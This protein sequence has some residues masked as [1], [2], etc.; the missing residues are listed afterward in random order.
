MVFSGQK[1]SGRLRSETATRNRYAIR[2]YLDTA[3]KHGEPVITAIRDALTGTPGCRPS[4]HEH[5]S[6]FHRSHNAIGDNTA[7]QA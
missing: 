6:A 1:I 5:N 7:G 4:P 3:R 2:G